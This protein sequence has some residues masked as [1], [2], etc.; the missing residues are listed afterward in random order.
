MGIS[1]VVLAVIMAVEKVEILS[2]TAI[3]LELVV[4]VLLISLPQIEEL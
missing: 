3:S 4:E 2:I 1:Q